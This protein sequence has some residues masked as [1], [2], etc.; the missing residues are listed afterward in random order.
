[1]VQ[2]RGNWIIIIL[3]IIVTLVLINLLFSIGVFSYL[4]NSASLFT[5]DFR[6][7]PRTPGTCARIDI[8]Y[9]Q[10]PDEPWA[11]YCED[12]QQQSF[13]YCYCVFPCGPPVLGLPDCIDQSDNDGD[14]LIDCLDP[15]CKAPMP[16]A[17]GGYICPS[18]DE[19]EVNGYYD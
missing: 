11:Q 12:M 18:D 9:G 17:P 8:L 3:I 14:G 16:S 6:L 19:S 4:Y 7:A 5:D 1:M 2:K 10:C 13:T 15:G